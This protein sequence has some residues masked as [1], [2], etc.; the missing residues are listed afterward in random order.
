MTYIFELGCAN[1]RTTASA[2]LLRYSYNYSTSFSFSVYRACCYTTLLLPSDVF[3]ARDMTGVSLA[4]IDHVI[5]LTA[6]AGVV[7]WRTYTISLLRSDGKIPRVTLTPMGPH[8]DLVVRR[9][10]FAS[11]DLERASLKQPKE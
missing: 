8:M 3:S 6:A 9:T 7:H 4:G 5:S 11:A 1:K 2:R 10:Q